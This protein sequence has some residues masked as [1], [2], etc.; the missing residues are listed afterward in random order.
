MDL[1]KKLLARQNKSSVRTCGFELLLLFTEALFQSEETK[2]GL[3][4]T[5][6]LF[7]RAI[8]LQPLLLESPS[9][10]LPFA[11]PVVDPTL[12]LA[13]T[14]GTETIE[15]AIEQFNMFF[16]FMAA[17]TGR[18]M[19][20]WFEQFKARYLTLL[21]PHIMRMSGYD[22]AERTYTAVVYHANHTLPPPLIRYWVR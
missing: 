8:N 1:I 9:A 12:I 13:P 15:E 6:D 17:R 10:N 5:L 18:S 7:Q 19:E 16:E 11:P 2:E 3:D 4:E 20:F 21:Y 14:S 22:I